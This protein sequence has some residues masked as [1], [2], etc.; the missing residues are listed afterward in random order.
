[1]ENI[2]LF[3]DGGANIRSEDPTHPM[4]QNPERL[5]SKRHR[6]PIRDTLSC[7]NLSLVIPKT[8]NLGSGIGP[9]TPNPKP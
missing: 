7:K 3:A 1:V 6:S 9:K 2:R 4:I 5:R 8:L